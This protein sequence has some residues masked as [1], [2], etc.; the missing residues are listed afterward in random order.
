[1]LRRIPTRL[2]VLGLSVATPLIAFAQE[3]GHAAE[4]VGALPTV[5]Q[6][7]WTGVTAIIVFVVVLAVLATKVWP[8]IG[9]ALDERA[10]KIKSEIA[11]AENARKQAKDAL[12]QYE[13]SLAD[14]RAEAQRM[15]D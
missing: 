15:L 1:M 8:V 9:R 5:K 3:H 11:A 14:A 10:D 12:E 7:L 6:G 4:E 2:L 13:R